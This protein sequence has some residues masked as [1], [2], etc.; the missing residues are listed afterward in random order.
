MNKVCVWDG[1]HSGHRVPEGLLDQVSNRGD[2]FE[3]ID[4]HP[5]DYIEFFF[6]GPLVRSLGVK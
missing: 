1:Y 3:I 5:F 4:D 2:A 6:I